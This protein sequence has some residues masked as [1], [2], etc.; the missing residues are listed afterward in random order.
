MKQLESRYPCPVCLGVTQEKLHFALPRAKSPVETGELVLDHCARCGGVW[1]G[2]GEVQQLRRVDPSLLWGRIIRRS[3]VHRMQ[4]HQCHT[5]VARNE[6]K[7]PGC[8]WNLALECPVCARTMDQVAHSG[9]RLDVCRTCKGVW[10][11]HDELAVIWKL[12]ANALVKERRGIGE[13]AQLGS[14]VLLDAL[15]YDPFLAFYGV[16]AA[17]HLVGGAAEAMAH[18]PGALANVPGAIGGLAEAAG[19]VASSV[20]E[21][22]AE[23]ISGLFSG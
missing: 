20:F 18:V 21:T 7:C 22:I 17:G 1:F 11:D 23:I 8:G 16:Q 12:E 6:K 13:N 14:L 15:T 2:L 5:H 10:F 4:C 19:E 9:L 3:E